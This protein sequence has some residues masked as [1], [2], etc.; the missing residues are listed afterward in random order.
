MKE[1]NL[2]SINNYNWNPNNIHLLKNV[3]KQV[4][5]ATILAFDK[6]VFVHEDL[7][8]GNIL[9]KPKRNCEIKYNNKVLV[10]DKLEIIIMDLEKSKWKNKHFN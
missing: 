5:F 4:I 8:C 1:Y 3:I 7:H 2:G 9:L 10:L 6:I